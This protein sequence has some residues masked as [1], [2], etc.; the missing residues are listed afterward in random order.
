MKIRPA[1]EEDLKTIRHWF[2]TE[3]E[4]ISWAGPSIHFPITI[5]QLKIDIDWDMAD[6]YRLVDEN[7]ITIGFCQVADRFG[8]KHIS[9]IAIA[10]EV[11]GQKLSYQLMN[12]LRQEIATPDTKLSL[13]VYEDNIPAKRLYE[14][15]GFVVHS[16]PEDKKEL[17]GC[18]FMVKET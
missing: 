6:A 15:L 13:F 2:R 17:E 4:A 18:V 3:A 7:D 8:C 10:P 1:N 14:K 11:R 5:K 12:L 9:R 16:Y